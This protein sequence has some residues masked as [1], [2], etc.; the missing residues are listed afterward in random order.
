MTQKTNKNF[1][2][3][4][5][6]DVTDYTVRMS[7][8]RKKRESFGSRDIDV[9][10][11]IVSP[12]GLEGLMLSLYFLLVPYLTGALFLFVAIA[13]VRFEK[14]LQLDLASLFVI[15]AIGYE[16]IAL[17]I[18]VMIFFSYIKFLKNNRG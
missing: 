6:S 17:F 9:Y 13:H 12:A 14:F 8:I 15:W 4:D 11:Y 1:Y 10:D 7:V 2:Y 18:L 16:V 5:A 3:V